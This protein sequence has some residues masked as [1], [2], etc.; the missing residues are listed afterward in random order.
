MC[1]K[2][3]TYNHLQA[4][5][6]TVSLSFSISDN[7]YPLKDQSNKQWNT[8][9]SMYKELIRTIKNMFLITRVPYKT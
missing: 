8:V 9:K 3:I 6:S 4:L 7:Y 2:V 5:P 1:L